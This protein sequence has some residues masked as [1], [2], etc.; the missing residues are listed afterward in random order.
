MSKISN[1]CARE[2]LDS[3]GYPTIEVEASVGNSCVVVQVPSGAS[4]GLYEAVELRDLDNN[5]YNGKGVLQATKNVNEEIKSELLGIDVTQQEKID[6]TLIE[7]D[8]TD[9]KS[10]LGA[11]AILGVSLAVAKAASASLNLP[12]YKYLSTEEHFIMPNPMINIINGGMHANNNLDIQE[13]MIV[14]PADLEFKERI[15]KSAEVFHTL[16]SILNKDGY[17]VAVGDEGGFAPN[18]TNNNTALDYIMRAIETAGH[19]GFKI[20]LDIAASTFYQEDQKKYTINNKVLNSHELTAY[21]QDLYEQY[22]IF[23]IEDG[24]AEQD[25]DGWQYMTKTFGETL[26]LVGDDVFVTNPK[27]LQ[28]GIDNNIANA[29]LI[30]PNQIGTLTETLQT[31]NIATT[32]K[33]NAIVSHRSGETEDTTIAHIAVATNCGQIKTG[34]LS[35]SERIAKYNELLR[36]AE[37]E[38]L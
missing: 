4:V 33:Y 14:P 31:I 34:S 13:F 5:R 19:D 18:L 2:I 15:R 12:L 22:P 21:Y 36:I 9:N 1:I 35:R 10:R 20:A 23:S 3:R 26:Q 11:N 30:K 17:S 38:K 32:N 29:I 7:L 28:S 24:M 6:Q 25:H 37:D 16:R 27:I 8:G